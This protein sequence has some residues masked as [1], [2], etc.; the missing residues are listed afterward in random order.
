MS[1][2]LSNDRASK[3]MK[4]RWLS[5]HASFQSLPIWVRVWVAAILIPINLLPFFFLDTAT[6][7]AAAVAAIFVTLTNVPIMLRERGMSRLMSVPHL[8]AWIPLLVFLIQHLLRPP[9]LANGEW[10]LAV[11]LVAINGLSL[12]FDAVDSWRWWR[13]E[14]GV[15]GQTL[16]V[17]Q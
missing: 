1:R 15:P 17:A 11:G 4:S 8:I 6:G 12:L 16:G 9:A 7:Q 13:G 14:R 3:S 10:L 5:C 2:H